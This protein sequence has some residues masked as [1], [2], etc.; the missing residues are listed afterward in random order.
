MGEDC[1]Y[2][3]RGKKKDFVDKVIN[4]GETCNGVG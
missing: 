3:G 2:W 1:D 4:S